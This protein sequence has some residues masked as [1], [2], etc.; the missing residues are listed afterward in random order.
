MCFVVI[1]TMEWIAPPLHQQALKRQSLA[2]SGG[3]VLIEKHGYWIHK[4]NRFINVRNIY[5]GQYTGRYPRL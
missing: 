4:D 2:L 5:Q 1:I 3:D